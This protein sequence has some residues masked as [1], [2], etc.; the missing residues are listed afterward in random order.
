M[1]KHENIIIIIE[2]F[3]LFFNANIIDK[4]IN[5]KEI[6]I[7]TLRKLLFLNAIATPIA[8]NNVMYIIYVR[9]YRK[10]NLL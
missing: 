10:K 3:N 4:T 9:G 2:I 1:N 5:T 7:E 6:I 8:N